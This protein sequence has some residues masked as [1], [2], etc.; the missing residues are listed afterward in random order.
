MVSPRGRR[1]WRI[2]GVAATVLAVL[3]GT[4]SLWSRVSELGT[5]KETQHETYDHAVTRV[6]VDLDGGA[7]VLVAG[8]PGRVVVERRLEWSDLRPTIV[9]TWTGDTLRITS[10]C[11][12]ARCSAGYSLTVPTDVEI[13]ARTRASRIRARGLAGP[14][15]LTTSSG[16]VRLT[17]TAGPVRVDTRAGAVT[18][19]GLRTGPVEVRTDAGD[20]DLRFAASPVALTATTGAGDVD[21]SVPGADAYRVTIETADGDQAIGVRQDSAATRTIAVRTTR[22]DIKIRYA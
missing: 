14:L 22:G 18:G 11:G 19:T 7:I 2:A 3:L 20:V 21:I 8:D 9:E 10:R 15:R 4:T 6:E 5:D 13:D 12:G 1:A 16:D 17:D